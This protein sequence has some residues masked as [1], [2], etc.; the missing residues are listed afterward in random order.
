[1][2]APPLPDNTAGVSPGTLEE[3][4]RWVG[5]ARWL[6]L[7]CFELLGGWVATTPEPEVKLAFARQSHHHAWHAEL[8]ERVLPSANGFSADVVV[9]PDA[10]GVLLE[11]L[12]RLTV[13][14]DRLV[15]AYELLM[16]GKVDEYERWY[17]AV[18]PVR[19]APLRR[20]LG[21]VVMDE[22]ADL[23]EGRVLLDGRGAAGAAPHREALVA[24]H[25]RAGRLLR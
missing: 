22:R 23:A 25:E 13:T 12:A 10:W 6:E 18:D 9:A 15:G 7:R 16:P 1:V 5:A 8:F 3:T 24:A 2:A 20:W 19:D 14:N 21:F 17:G 4:A 11:D